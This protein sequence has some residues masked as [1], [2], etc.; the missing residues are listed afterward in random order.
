MSDDVKTSL[1]GIEEM[2]RNLEQLGTRTALRGPSAA[3]RA[4]GSVIVKEMRRRAPRE[5]GSLRKSLGQKVKTYKSDGTTVAIIG[6]RSRTFQTSKGRRNPANYA[7]LVEKGSAPH[8]LGRG[9]RHPG[10][11]AKP[12]MRPAW[13]AQAPRARKAAIDKMTKIF[14]KESR[15][16]R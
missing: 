11:A 1:R 3:V 9:G 15:R 10:S 5:T 8:R 7:H 4:A 13:D 12:F 2:T 16:V 6:A 14:E